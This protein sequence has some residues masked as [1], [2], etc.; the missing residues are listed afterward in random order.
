MVLPNYPPAPLAS[1]CGPYLGPADDPNRQVEGVFLRI[2]ARPSVASGR[3]SI[4][5]GTQRPNATGIS[6]ETSGSIES[7]LGGYINPAAFSTAP[8]YTYG[9]VSRTIPMRGP[10]QAFTDVSLSKTFRL[11]EGVKMLFKADAFNMTNTPVFYG[12]NTQIGTA[13]FG[14]ITSQANFPRVIQLGVR[15]AL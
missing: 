6:P 8:Q 5:V 14:Q 9:N 11:F 3:L 7:R 1:V 10:S 15:F 4:G 2:H 12:P 13:T